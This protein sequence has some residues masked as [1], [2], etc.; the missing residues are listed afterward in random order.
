M[1]VTVYRKL[2]CNRTPT[3]R[4]GKEIGG[5]LSSL[6]RF[7]V[8]NRT[9]VVYV[10]CRPCQCHTGSTAKALPSANNPSFH[11]APNS[12][13]YG[14]MAFVKNS[15]ASV[16][17]TVELSGLDVLES[18]LICVLNKKLSLRHGIPY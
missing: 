14:V 12:A 15:C 16:I 6:D 10:T 2:G 8:G 3:N 4:K 17:N 1:N 18:Y 5:S 9:P 7:I 11:G 13:L